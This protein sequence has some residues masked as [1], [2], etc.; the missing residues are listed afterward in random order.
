MDENGIWDTLHELSND[1]KNNEISLTKIE[2][3]INVISK[4]IIVVPTVISIITFIGNYLD[5]LMNL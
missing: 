1:V 4:A 3:Q 5:W 2:T